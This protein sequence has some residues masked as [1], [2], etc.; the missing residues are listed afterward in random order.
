MRLF[1][2]WRQRREVKRLSTKAQEQY[3]KDSAD[4][5]TMPHEQP[6]PPKIRKADHPYFGGKYPGAGGR[7]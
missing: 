3:E 4:L 7:G 2:R 5:F 1:K 6:G